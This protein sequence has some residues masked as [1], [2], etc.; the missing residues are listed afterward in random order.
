MVRMEEAKTL[1]FG[2]IWREYCRREGRERR[3]ELVRG[4]KGLQAGRAEQAGDMTPGETMFTAVKP[5]VCKEYWDLEGD[6][7]GILDIKSYRITSA[8]V[9]TGGNR[10]GTSATAAT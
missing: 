2:D 8:C 6:N 1:P 5:H 7:M 3:R 4:C 10:A 9:P